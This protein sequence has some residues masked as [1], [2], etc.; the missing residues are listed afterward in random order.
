MKATL[1]LDIDVVMVSLEGDLATLLGG[2]DLESPI[3]EFVG[4]DMGVKPI[5]IF[6][7]HIASL[8]ARVLRM[9]AYSIC[10]AI[11]S[12]RKIPWGIW[13]SFCRS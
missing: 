2:L 5:G 6:R 13:Q 10:D 9:N 4:T 3:S 1:R 12:Q 11:N 8:L 7:C